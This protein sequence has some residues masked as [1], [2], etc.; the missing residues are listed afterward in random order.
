MAT[1]G[2]LLAVFGAVARH[3][4]RAGIE[5][6]SYE[7]RA[8]ARVGGPAVGVVGVLM[9]VAAALLAAVK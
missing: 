5:D 7:R 6:G 1:L 2:A 3:W 9:V 4:S 8:W